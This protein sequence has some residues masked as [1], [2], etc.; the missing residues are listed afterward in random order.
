MEVTSRRVLWEREADRA[1]PMASTTKILTALIVAEDC[2]PDAAVT[3][4]EEA[5]GVEGSSVYLRAGETLTVRDLL[6]GLLLRS[7]NDCAVALALQHSG[8]V[9]AFS[10]CMNARAA[11]LGAVHSH[12]CNP[13]GLPAAGHFTTAHDLALIASAALENALVG[14]A[15][16]S[17]S[18]RA[19]GSGGVRV[20]YNKNKMLAQYEGA[21]GVKTG[22]T[23]EAGRC[24]VASARRGGMH[25]V[26]VVL[27][28]PDMYARS[29][30]LLD[31]A[32]A[33]F[34]MKQLFDAELFCKV[35]PTDVRGKS[36]ALACRESFWY[37]L[38]EE[39]EGQVRT[40]EA[41]PSRLA[42]PVRRGDAVGELKI[43]LK[44]QLLFCQKIVSIEDKEKSY[45]DILR[46][47][48]RS[49]RQKSKCGSTNTWPN[50]A[51]PAAAPATG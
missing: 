45:F 30:A 16:S 29:S 47:L 7:G 39:E 34:S 41:L 25:L 11:S 5:A 48:T 22:Y 1:L 43:Y 24:L 37:P 26:S 17:P 13:H 8:S 46:E 2:D 10:A 14:A 9:E 3:V 21:D 32:F 27:N 33:R 23:A 4:P 51:S 20:W 40:E 49:G 18:Y 6:Y 19:E 15:V 12:F 31:A 28:S 44:N 35:L 36:C 50:A 42:L 38:A